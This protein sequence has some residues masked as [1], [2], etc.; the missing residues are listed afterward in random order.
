MDPAPMLLPSA[1]LLGVATAAG[2]AIF[3][4]SSRAATPAL[5]AAIMP[6]VVSLSVLLAA[7]GSLAVG[8]VV[9]FGCVMHAGIVIAASRARARVAPRRD[10]VVAALAAL[11]AVA[12]A[13][14]G[15]VSS[16]GKLSPSA[17]WPCDAVSASLHN[18][19]DLGKVTRVLVGYHGEPKSP[20]IECW[21]KLLSAAD[22]SEEVSLGRGWS[23]SGS[24]MCPGADVYA[25]MPAG[26]VKIESRSF[27]TSNAAAVP[28]SFA[29]N[30]HIFGPPAAYLQL[31]IVGALAAALLAALAARRL[32]RPRDDPGAP[33]RHPYRAATEANAIVLE[34]SR[35]S[36]I[37]FVA[38][39]AALA[40]ATPLAVALVFP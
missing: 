37:A 21:A 4:R 23:V 12:T 36:R 33:D 1:V 31:A 15:L 20:P 29:G 40:S 17:Q 3:G 30:M 8:F 39:T 27:R 16:K 24:V 2:A 34:D 6:A 35:A 26:L 25:C 18:D 28:S 22:E 38:V 19:V 11:F 5:A 7:L 9:V 14:L 32:R 13:A 10:V